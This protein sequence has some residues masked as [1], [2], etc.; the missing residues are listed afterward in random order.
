M[1]TNSIITGDCRDVL[2]TLPAGVADLVVTDP[3]FNI[4]YPYP[5]YDDSLT[6]DEYLDMLEG[7]S[8]RCGGC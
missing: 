5:G 3:P 4:G 6:D 1:N 8:A 7:P 2:R